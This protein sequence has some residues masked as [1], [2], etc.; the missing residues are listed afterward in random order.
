MRRLVLIMASRN[1]SPRKTYFSHIKRKTVGSGFF[2]NSCKEFYRCRLLCCLNAFQI[3]LH[4]YLIDAEHIYLLF[5]PLTPS[6]YDA[7]IKFLNKSYNDYFAI[8]FGRKVQTWQ[9]KPVVRLLPSVKLFLDSQKFIERLPL[10]NAAYTHPGECTYSSYCSNAFFSNPEYLK[11]HPSLSAFLGKDRG[12]L[13]RYRA[14]IARPFQ[15]SYGVFLES[16][17]LF[18]RP[19]LR[20]NMA[21][22]LE[23]NTTLTDILKSGTM[24]NA[25]IGNCI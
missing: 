7:F 11:R 3:E 18:G 2:D 12:S 19:F 25:G 22:R 20:R 8:R 15:E 16:R 14:F 17:L 5:T 13:Q 23:K 6:G 4:A 10:K 1:L 9:N 21:S 24:A